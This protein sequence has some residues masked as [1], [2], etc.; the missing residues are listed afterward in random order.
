L[1]SRR[2]VGRGAHAGRGVADRVRPR[3]GI[4]DEVRERGGWHAAVHDQEQRHRAD[5]ADGHQI[6]QRVVGHVPHQ[7]GIDGDVAGV[8]DAERVAVGRGLGDRVHGDIATRAR[9][10]VD[11]HGLAGPARN[12][13]AQDARGDIGHP[14]GRGGNDDLERLCGIGLGEGGKGSEDD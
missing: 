2:E 12:V 9:A 3:L 4:G 11:H 5:R 1:N 7:V 14:A 8:G 13:R 10:V 6:V